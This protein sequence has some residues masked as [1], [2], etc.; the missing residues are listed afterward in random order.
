MTKKIT[1][2]M[3]WSEWTDELG[4]TYRPGDIVAIA[5]INGRSPQMI[6]ARVDRINKVNSYGEEI[7]TNKQ[8]ELDEPIRQVRECYV[9]KRRKQND[10]YYN[11]Y[12]AERD[13]THVCVPECTEWWQTS[14]VR[15]VPSCTVK[16]TPIADLRGFGRSRNHDG[17]VKSNTYSIPENI[18]FI[19][20]GS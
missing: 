11:R 4:N 1:E 19:E 10:A 12:Y 18:I 17:K 8:F 6:I 9:L 5:I 14:E 16:A 13:S 7:R 15:N 20:K 2:D 3:V